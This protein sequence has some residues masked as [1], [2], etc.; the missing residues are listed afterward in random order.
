MKVYPEKKKKK[1]Q[2]PDF[3]DIL[4][5]YC[6]EGNNTVR[7]SYTVIF[8]KNF[9]GH[10]TAT[11]TATATAQYVESVSQKNLMLWILL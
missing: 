9:H 7:A 6:K 8:F 2:W 10:P 11:A 4:Q 5:N 3:F 1:K